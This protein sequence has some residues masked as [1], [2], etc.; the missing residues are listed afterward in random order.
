MTK[1]ITGACAMQQVERGK[2]SLDAPIKTVLP[3]L[4][5]AGSARR[6][7]LRGQSEDAPRARRHHASPSPYPHLGMRLRLL[8]RRHHALHREDR[9]ARDH[10]LRQR[11]AER[12]VAVRSR[13]DMA[14]RRRNRLRRQGGGEGHRPEARQLHEG[15][16]LRPARHEGHRVQDRRRAA[17][18][19][20]QDPRAH[21]RGFRRHRH[22]NPAGAGVRD[23]RRRALRHGRRLSQVRA[24]LLARGQRSMGR[25]S[26][27]PK[28]S[29]S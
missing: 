3:E 23:G 10:F 24:G 28:P 15:E 27:S 20:G 1:A 8:E 22:R 18:A 4:A 19:A 7:R 26:S 21:A 6:L 17:Q 5:E 11:R 16:H 29:G 13:R 2:L 14:I 12:A 9:N 25:R